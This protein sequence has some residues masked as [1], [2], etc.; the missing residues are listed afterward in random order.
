MLPV[1]LVALMQDAERCQRYL[2]WLESN[3]GRFPRVPFTQLLY[4]AEF[5]GVTG[6][7][8][9]TA[10]PSN[11]AFLFIPYSLCL[12]AAKAQESPIRPALEEYKTRFPEEDEDEDL[13]I[14]VTFERLQGDSSFFAPYFDVAIVPTTLLLDWSDTDLQTLHNPWLTEAV[15]LI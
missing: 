10:I 13:C 15:P 4:P 1:G 11:T 14:Y 12:T 6:V 9:S 7:A 2:R 5:D 3:G 8:A